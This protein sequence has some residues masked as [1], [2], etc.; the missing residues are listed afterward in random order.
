MNELF[1]R[2]R[3]SSPFSSS[4]VFGVSRPP[5]N[6]RAQRHPMLF[7]NG[8]LYELFSFLEIALRCSK[9]TDPAVSVSVGVSACSC[10]RCPSS[11]CDYSTSKAS[12]YFW[13][14]LKGQF[15]RKNSRGLEQT[16]VSQKWWLCIQNQ[17]RIF[18]L[19][20]EVIWQWQVCF[21]ELTKNQENVIA[22]GTSWRLRSY[23]T[24]LTK[25]S[26]PGREGWMLSDKTLKGASHTL[27]LLLRLL[28]CFLYYSS[29]STGFP[30]CIYVRVY[31]TSDTGF[32]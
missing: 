6:S 22:S 27:G 25:D 12:V 9:V 19:E 32:P 4:C 11:Q 7:L 8:Y 20:L 21:W 15:K 5:R 1:R 16:N 26:F 2:D 17:C 31:S 28:W 29:I 30:I 10:P 13:H 18:L 24:A 14:L 3:S 23:Q